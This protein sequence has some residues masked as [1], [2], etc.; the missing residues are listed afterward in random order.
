MK[1]LIEL[2]G[3]P[4]APRV[5]HVAGHIHNP[6]RLL[7]GW[8]NGINST[9]LVLII[10]GK[11]R[12]AAIDAFRMFLPELRPFQENADYRLGTMSAHDRHAINNTPTA[13]VRT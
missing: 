7:D 10:S 2:S 3:Y 11:G 5:V 13:P 1:G 6:P 8:P 4:D 9:R 12:D